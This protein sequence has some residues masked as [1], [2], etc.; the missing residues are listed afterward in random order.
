[1]K[2]FLSIALTALMVAALA[3]PTF[4]STDIPADDVDNGGAG[5][6]FSVPGCNATP[7]LDGAIADGEYSEIATKTSQ[8]SKAVSDD[9]NDGVA[10]AIYT[11]AKI[12]MT[13]DANYIYYATTFTA[14]NDFYSP[15]EGDEGN[16]WYSSALQFCYANTADKAD[17]SSTNRL[18][19][20][21]GVT[22]AGK[23]LATIWANEEGF[24]YTADD[25]T[26]NF[27]MKVDGSTVTLE[28][29][30]PWSAF[31]SVS[32][33]IG[34]QVTLCVV[35]SVGADQ[36]Y[37]HA[38]LAAGCTGAGGK[39]TYHQATLTLADAPAVPVIEEVADETPAADAAA[40]TS[41]PAATTG[42][43]QTSDAS[44]LFVLL[45]VAALG[46]AVVVSKKVRG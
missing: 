1:M 38:Q 13:W 23:N 16:M 34:A 8:W 21:V 43:A 29:R 40:D 2:K 41:A 30:T 35:Y 3:V 4:A 28:L 19:F 39:N 11:N 26:G 20:G 7:T 6:E 17:T 44:A 27:A 33:A 24:D 37:V 36:D 5:I 14:P 46:T 12:Y 10:E 45:A 22:S 9:A 42:A 31:T 18:E 25:I 15:W 32:P